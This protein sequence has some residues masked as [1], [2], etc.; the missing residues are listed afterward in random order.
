MN[1]NQSGKFGLGIV[2][3]CIGGLLILSN[4]GV[5]PNFGRLIGLFWPLIII[6][7][8]LMFHFGY[9]SNRNHVGL[10]VPGGVLLTVG[11]VCQIS[12]LWGLWDFMWPGFILAPAVGLF[13]LY[14]FGNREKGLLIP[15]SI[16]SGLSLIFFTMTFHTLGTVARYMI[17]AALILTGAI[18][19]AKDKKQQNGYQDYEAD[20]DYYEDGNNQM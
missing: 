9:Y 15:V 16:L 2:L 20:Q 8:S 18:V 14:L 1:N 11:V 12:M 6:F 19:L 13:E 17:P 10:L 7:M 5:V 3:V 4:L